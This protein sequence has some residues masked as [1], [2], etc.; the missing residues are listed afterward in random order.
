MF[1]A[2]TALVRSGSVRLVRPR[3]SLFVGRV[4]GLTWRRSGMLTVEELKACRATVAPQNQEAFVDLVN[5]PAIN[6][7][8]DAQ[9]HDLIAGHIIDDRA[10]SLDGD[11][12]TQQGD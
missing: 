3:L 4:Q 5:F 8:T 11:N 7:I 1:A 2:A 9:P 12:D 10:W 6:L